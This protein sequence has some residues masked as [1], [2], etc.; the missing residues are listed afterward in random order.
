MKMRKHKIIAKLPHF[1]QIQNASFKEDDHQTATLINN[2]EKTVLMIDPKN[3][4]MV[5]RAIKLDDVIHTYLKDHDYK[6]MFLKKVNIFEASDEQDLLRFLSD[7][8]DFDKIYEQTF[9]NTRVGNW[10]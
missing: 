5:A 7:V 8:I 3:S 1:Y 2:Y 10:I 9:Y 4:E 6:V